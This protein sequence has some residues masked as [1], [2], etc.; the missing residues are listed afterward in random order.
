VAG[1]LFPCLRKEMFAR[2]P[3]ARYRIG[4]FPAMSVVCVLSLAF[5]TWMFILLWNDPIAA[6]HSFRSVWGNVGL[7]IAG[8]VIYVVMRYIRRRQGVRLELAFKQIPIE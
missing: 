6:G 1:A 2:W 8:F 5:M 3:V 4:P 7:L